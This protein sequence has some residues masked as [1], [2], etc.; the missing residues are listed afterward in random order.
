MPMILSRDQVLFLD[1]SKK[2]LADVTKRNWLKLPLSKMRRSGIPCF[3]LF[4]YQVFNFFFSSL[5]QGHLDPLH[6]LFE[7]TA[8]TDY[9]EGVSTIFFEF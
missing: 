1:P 3:F 6:G 9:Y 4:I 7:F 5:F 2:R 8:E